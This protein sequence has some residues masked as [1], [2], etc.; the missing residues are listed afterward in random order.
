MLSDLYLSSS[1]MTLTQIRES[2]RKCGRD[3]SIEPLNRM[4]NG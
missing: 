3:L 1:L 4:A 2:E